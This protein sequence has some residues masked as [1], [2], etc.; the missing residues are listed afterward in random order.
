MAKAATGDGFGDRELDV[1][2]WIFKESNDLIKIVT[3]ILAVKRTIN[4]LVYIYAITFSG[5]LT[6]G[7][8]MFQ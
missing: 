2:L 1:W 3:S 4:D 8:Q 7:V 6:D 5:F